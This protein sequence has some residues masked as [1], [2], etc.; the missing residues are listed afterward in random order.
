MDNERFRWIKASKRPSAGTAILLAMP[1][2][3]GS[4]WVYEFGGYYLKGDVFHAV[5]KDITIKKDGYYMY[6]Q[7]FNELL[8]L[9]DVKY[10]TYIKEPAD[11]RDELVIVRE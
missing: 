5:R 9:P 4:E 2:L 10:Y 11:I 7:R 6:S 3:D 1:A 8:R